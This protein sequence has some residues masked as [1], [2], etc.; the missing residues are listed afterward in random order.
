MSALGRK[1]TPKLAEVYQRDHETNYA[2]EHRDQP[3]AGAFA[4]QH[5]NEVA[6]YDRQQHFQQ[7]PE[8]P[9]YE[10]PIRATR[11]MRLP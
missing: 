2:E 7:K 11:S 1:R 10:E 8:A 9:E 3:N 5:I 4:R 6:E